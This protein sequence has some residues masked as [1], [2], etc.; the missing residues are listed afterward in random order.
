ML[1]LSW[2]M[3]CTY[4]S[5]AAS[6]KKTYLE[7]IVHNEFFIVSFSESFW[8]TFDFELVAVGKLI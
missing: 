6:S 2:T 5:M 4:N 8:V 7:L 3:V 1:E